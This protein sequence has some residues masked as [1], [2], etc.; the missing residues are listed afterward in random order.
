MATVNIN[1]ATITATA[2]PFGGFRFEITLPS[3]ERYSASSINGVVDGA[4]N[5]RR[6]PEGTDIRALDQIVASFA[7][8]QGP[9]L[10]AQV[11]AEIERQQLP[12]AQ[13]QPA[14]SASQQVQAQTA[15]TPQPLPPSPGP[16]S[17]ANIGTAAP[18]KPLEE[19]QAITTASNNGVALRP[20]SSG[21]GAEGTAGEA[22]AAAAVLKQGQGAKDDAR[23][24]TPP[25]AAVD[26]TETIE[27]NIRPRPNVL[28]EF[29][30]YTY[31][32]S[33]YLLSLEQSEQLLKSNVKRV[34]GYNLLF[35]SAGAANNRGGPRDT[36]AASTIDPTA[37]DA[38]RNPYFENDFYIDAITIETLP[39]GKGTNAVHNA[40]S[41]KFTLVEPNGITLL[42]RLYDAVANFEPRSA[43]GAVNYTAVSYLMVIRFYGYDSMGQPVEI[44][45][46]QYDAEG[47]SSAGA[48]VEKFIPFRVN[49]I[50]WSVGSKM[51][52]YEWE[53]T[54]IGQQIGGYT[55]RGTIPYDVQLTETTV[56]KLLMGTTAFSNQSAAATAP[57]ASTTATANTQQNNARG[58]IAATTAPAKANAAPTDK[59]NLVQGLADALNQFQ[60]DNVKRG[61]YTYADVYEIEF[62]GPGSEKIRDAVLQSAGQNP[63]A[64]TASGRPATLDPGGLRPATNSVDKTT[65]NFSITAGQ[66]ILQVIDL[67]IRNSSYVYDQALVIVDK[68]GTVKPN[69][70][71]KNQQVRWYNIS[72]QA[73][74]ISKELDPKR[75]DYAYRIKYVISPFVVKNLDSI[76]YP[77]PKFYGVHKSY[78]YWF[79]GQ[80]SAVLDYTEKLNGL[81][82]LT[83]SGEVPGNTNA[84]LLRDRY[85]ASLADIIKYSYAPRSS[86]SS[87]GAQGKTN[88]LGANAAESLLSPG[89]IGEATVK[90]IGDPDWIQQGSIFRGANNQTFDAQVYNTGFLPDGSISF[91]SQDVLFEIVWKRPND[92]DVFTGKADPYVR[93]AA[94]YNNYSAEQ[95]RVYHCK[96]VVSEFR[97]GRF[98]QTLH[99]ALY[100]FPK[101][102]QTN[103][104]NPAAASAAR[105]EEQGGGRENVGAAAAISNRTNDGTLGPTRR[106]AALLNNSAAGLVDPA[107]QNI[108]RL[109]NNSA[110]AAGAQATSSLARVGPTV[111]AARE[112][113]LSSAI[114]RVTVPVPTL[115]AQPR[116]PTSGTGTS[117]Q[118]VTTGAPNR[119]PEADPRAGRL[120]NTQIQDLVNQQ[121]SNVNTNPASATNPAT[122]RGVVDS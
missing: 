41:L 37:A 112:A 121:S 33:V 78:P 108:L 68:D 11:R 14:Q 13:T 10:E 3:G 19:S 32:A 62:V 7:Q 55:A 8:V 25:T 104:A 48:V 116:P 95:S 35:Q 109:Q 52:T 2:S 1:G 67:V 29:A 111:Q 24:T 96:K 69:P 91:D 94:K 22:E 100:L 71:T 115:Y 110:A 92:Y 46:R 84:A 61:I 87:A 64:Q 65:K 49:N 86:E 120:T 114:N 107:L 102:N 40:T 12:P 47:V 36:G 21:A 106:N 4:R 16:V 66:Q 60:Q 53:C 89:D 122:Q 45:S 113:G 51:V 43:T 31:S 99:G 117:V 6:D 27:P 39:M 5:L 56:G 97:Q 18:T 38:G 98:E 82:H 26:A 74:R 9:A 15:Q 80:N 63:I 44:R 118:A 105:A 57:G 54:P 88:E 77:V 90:I 20:P 93:S 30:S 42:E 73:E 59:K 72:M 81:Y 23:S 58:E 79:T 101:P 70:N 28:D 50:N 75:N 119:L 103:A 76:Y 17:A 85:T 83:I 34:D